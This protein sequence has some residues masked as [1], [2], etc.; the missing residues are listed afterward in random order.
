MDRETMEEKVIFI[1][2]TEYTNTLEKN[3]KQKKSW[4]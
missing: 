3:N 2:T 1:L 4:T